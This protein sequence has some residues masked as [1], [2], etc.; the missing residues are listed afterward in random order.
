MDIV[1]ALW[2]VFS[3]FIL[4]ANTSTPEGAA[5]GVENLNATPEAHRSDVVDTDVPI[6]ESIQEQA[7]SKGPQGRIYRDLTRPHVRNRD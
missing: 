4:G 2:L 6:R 1:V 7:C 3:A 5:A